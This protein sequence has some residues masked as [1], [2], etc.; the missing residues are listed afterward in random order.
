MDGT[1]RVLVDTLTVRGFEQDAVFAL[2]QAD[3]FAARVEEQVRAAEDRVRVLVLQRDRAED[4]AQEA[5][6]AL[7]AAFQKSKEFEEELSVAQREV[8]PLKVELERAREAAAARSLERDQAAMPGA[9]PGQNLAHLE[10]DLARL[11]KRVSQS[12]S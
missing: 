12:K 5:L 11:A 8:G 1:R 10:K 6:A 4:Q 2:R 7:R 3:A 9:G